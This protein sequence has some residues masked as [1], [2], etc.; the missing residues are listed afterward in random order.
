VTEGQTGSE[1]VREDFDGAV[2]TITLNRPQARN[3]LTTE[4]KEALLAALTRAASDTAVRAVILTGAPDAFCAGQDLREHADALAAGQEPTDTVRRHYN[5]IVTCLMTMPKPVVAAINGSAAGAGASLALACDFRV[6]S[7]RASLLLAFARVGLG[8]D[9]GASWTLQRLAGAGRA[10]E[11]LMLAE[12]IGAEPA[13]AAGLLTSVV[14]HDELAAA[15]G[16]LARRLADGPT[17]AYAAIKAELVYAASHGLA[18]S[19]EKE[20]ELQ[21][22][23]GRTAD[24]QAATLAF[25]RKERPSFQGR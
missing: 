24:H 16:A 22:E 13:L 14:A 12:P 19:L 15:A 10:A 5:R 6:A 4:M 18:D 7:E 20:A 8:A 3:A 9:S 23:L 21:T 1:S 2:A 25:L 17:A 11:L